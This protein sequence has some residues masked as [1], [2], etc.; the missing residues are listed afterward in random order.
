M[1]NTQ[2]LVD[3]NLASADELATISGIGQNLAKK[4]IDNRPYDSIDDLTTIPGISETKLTVLKPY[5][6][7]SS[8]SG[9]KK[10]ASK[11]EPTQSSGEKKPITTLGETEAFVF[12]EDRNERQDALLIL[13]GGF[14]LGLVILL[15]RR[16]HD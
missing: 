13:F 12:L 3:I 2:A 9:R 1:A 16:A 10:A 11:P 6:T 7:L 15:L 5:M 8:P 14:I 4:I